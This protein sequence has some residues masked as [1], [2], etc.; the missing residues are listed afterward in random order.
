[1]NESSSQIQPAYLTIGQLCVYSG[2]CRTIL[3]KWLQAGMPHYRI[4][5]SIRVRRN[6]FD[7]WLEQFRTEG[8]VPA[9]R[10]VRLLDEAVKEASA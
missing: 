6:D 10:L 8:T 7:K 2:V 1:M 9:D 4:G 5:R 3:R